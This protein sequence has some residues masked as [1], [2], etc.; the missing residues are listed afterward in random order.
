MTIHDPI[1]WLNKHEQALKTKQKGGKMSINQL[2][3]FL[4]ASY[5]QKKDK[6][7]IDDYKIDK[8]L[9]GQRVQVYHDPKT[10]KAVVVH[11]GTQGLNDV[12][13]DL[14]YGV[15]YK[16]KRFKHAEKIQKEAQKKYGNENITTTGHSLGSLI[17]SNV[18]KNSKE[19]I[20]YNKPV[21]PL[22]LL[23]KPN[24]NEHNVRTSGDILSILDPFS[25][26]DTKT[27]K[28]KTHNPLIEHSTNTL[29]NYDK[30]IEIGEGIKHDNISKLD[31]LQHSIHYTGGSINEQ[32]NLIHNAYND[33]TKDELQKILIQTKEQLKDKDKIIDMLENEIPTK[34][35]FNTKNIEL[36]DIL[37]FHKFNKTEDGKI[38][39]SNPDLYTYNPFESAFDKNLKKNK[40][41]YRDY[42]KKFIEDWSVSAQELVILY[43]GVGSGKTMIAVNCA[44]QYQ[45]ITNNAHIYFLTPASLVLGTIKECYD[46]GIQANRKNDK[47]DYI[48]YFVSYQQLLRSNFDF[49]ENSLLI[50]DE[51]HNLRNITADEIS[52]KIS[53][54]KYKRTGNYS[55]VGNKLSEKLIQTSSKFLRSIFMTGT[56]FVNGS[57][58]IEALMAIGYKKQPLL[59]I[60]KNKYENIINSDTEFKIYYEGLISFYRVPKVS[61]M[62]S[63]KFEFIPIED[64]NLEYKIMIPSKKT[65]QLIQEPYFMESRN[66][67]I[68]KKVDWVLKFLKSH[69][70]E[71]T[72]IYSQF[73]EKSLNPLLEQLD[74]KKIKYGFISG[75]LSQIEK[76]NVVKKYND[77]E[78]KV[79]IFTLSI[80]EGISFKETNNIIVFQPY[81]NY[82]IM[83]QI[84][85]RG[86]RLTSHALKNKAI[87][88]LYFLV[89]VKN[90]ND[91]KKWFE[92]ADKIMNNDIKELFF[93]V[94]TDT[95]GLKIKELGQV[96]NDY[97]SRDINLYNRMFRKQEEINIFEKRLLELPRFENVNNNENNEFI[98]EYKLKLLELEHQTGKVPTNKESITLKKKMYKDYY[99]KKIKNV[100]S[101]I[102]RFNDDNRYKHNRNPNLEEKASENKFGDKTTEIKSLINKKASI[103]DF[104]ELFKISKQDITL[105]QANFTP[106]NEINIVI[107]KSGIKNDIRENLK[108][109]EP[110]AGIGNF[111]EQ[112][113]KLDNKYNFMI[114]CN[115][116]NNA[117]YQI[118]KTMYEDIDNVKWLNSDFWIYQNK[119]NYDY[120]LG[121]PPFNLAHQILEKI[122]YKAQKD[123][124]TPEPTYQKVDK[125][126]YD[127][128]FVSKAYNLLNNDG[129]LSMIISDRFMRTQEGVFSIFNLFLDDMKKIDPSS[130]SIIKTTEFKQNKKNVAK[131]METNFGMVCITLKKL[132]NFNIDLESKKRI[133]NIVNEFN[134][135]N[136]KE[137]KEKLKEL[138]ITNKT[139]PVK[140]R[141]V[142]VKKK[143]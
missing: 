125:R 35:Q 96:N 139:I 117:F 133:N 114:D 80:K 130:V 91:T 137:T 23:K 37:N 104:L 40:N 25:K 29:D 143:L 5:N 82:A 51:A 64:K 115:E 142:D 7:D 89:G 129:V 41:Y 85:A 111:I 44:E 56:L 14:A 120:I 84:L 68:D 113:L 71:K 22:D 49:K 32:Q 112:L 109:L 12:V 27:L 43:Y 135:N 34:K 72:L 55:L 38:L 92:N 107:E 124:P 6:S 28:S 66:Q 100:D 74:K 48:Y 36:Y 24:K 16:T 19:I 11:R 81:W 18:G 61:S 42:Q 106:P 21:T 50:I 75:A 141:K 13:T 26:D 33:L 131:S 88:N 62:P 122:E 8:D 103:E 132:K 78:I 83:E 136:P 67:A 15:G 99:D 31:K 3:K 95:D 90:I 94:K 58:D 57:Q 10:N 59:N 77:D 128:H 123:K 126:L 73:L 53:A 119:Y 39:E 20:N 118:G 45:E 30:N 98:E 63:K 47:G 108:I 79:I 105:F 110:T 134:K 93:P 70:N 1:K 102:I 46:R 2:Q 9:S 4:K 116:Y 87:I 69:K 65:G 52:E 60:D 101:R 76:L 138:G 140:K 127:I 54:R 121:N 17:S 97:Q 86:I